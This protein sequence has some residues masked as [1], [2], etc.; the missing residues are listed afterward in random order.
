MLSA[1]KYLILHRIRTFDRSDKDRRQLEED[2]NNLEA[3]LY[4]VRDLLT[5]TT[6]TSFASKRMIKDIESIQKITSTWLSHVAGS[7]TSQDLKSRLKQ[8]E[9]LVAPIK[10][11]KEEAATRPELTEYLREA[12][13]QAKGL[14]EVIKENLESAKSVMDSSSESST[15][16]VSSDESASESSSTT[17]APAESSATDP[18][19]DLEEADE[20]STTT[21]TSNAPKSTEEPFMMPYTQADL[22]EMLASYESV[23]TW[24]EKK[25]VEQAKLKEWD[26]PVLL[27]AD[28]QQK[29]KDLNDALMK[30]LQNKMR[31]PSSS[32]SRSKKPKP[33]KKASKKDE[34]KKD[35]KKEEKKKDK[36]KDEL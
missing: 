17:T 26:D 23:N 11:R 2:H 32:K 27:S 28:M 36:V 30:L 31:K 12:L 24:L 35:E 7:T 20:S 4:K 34:E 18:L 10:S 15:A 8:L 14:V 21:A 19:A 3:Y 33:T 5:D 29:A 6:F 9:D 13:K 16:K 25:L 22:D 1:I